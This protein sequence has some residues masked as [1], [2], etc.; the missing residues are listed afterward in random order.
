MFSL[1]YGSKPEYE[2]YNKS[3]KLHSGRD[4]GNARWLNGSNQK[5]RSSKKPDHNSILRGKQSKLSESM[6]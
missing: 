5:H 6:N 3:S 1:P 2:S 4:S